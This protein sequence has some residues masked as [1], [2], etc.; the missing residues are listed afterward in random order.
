MALGDVELMP[1]DEVE[2]ERRLGNLQRTLE[3]G[4][5]TVEGQLATLTAEEGRLADNMDNIR[6]RVD[7][8]E[9]PS[10]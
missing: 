4:F 1:I 10:L 6:G 3:V 9:D 7:T 5:A 8:L 2:L